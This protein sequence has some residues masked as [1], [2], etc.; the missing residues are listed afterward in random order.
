MLSLLAMASR[1]AFL[2]WIPVSVAFAIVSVLSTSDMNSSATA[3]NTLIFVFLFLLGWANS[4]I[5]GMALERRIGVFLGLDGKTE[6]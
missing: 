2:A 6:E 4:E 1:F 3:A 5:R